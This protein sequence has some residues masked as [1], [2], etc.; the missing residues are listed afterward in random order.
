M[1]TPAATAMLDQADAATR[2]ARTVVER[3][4]DLTATPHRGTRPS[5]W[6]AAQ[7]LDLDRRMADRTITLCPHIG[8]APQ[9][10]HAVAWRPGTL[11]CTR[12]ATAM[13][14]PTDTED[15]TCD[16]CR[17]LADPIHSGLVTI[18]PLLF[19][20][21]LCDPCARTTGH[22]TTPTNPRHE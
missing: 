21:G 6:L 9:I 13:L 20:F 11:A 7:L 15:Q 22:L 1:P 5:P 2:H 18:G 17:H 10:V 8:D 4:A 19:G 3:L 16:R 14:T 12:C